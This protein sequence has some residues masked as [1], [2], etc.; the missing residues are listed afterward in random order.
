MGALDVALNSAVTIGSGAATTILLDSL[1]FSADPP[2]PPS[3]CEGTIEE[4]HVHGDVTP[5]RRLH[6]DGVRVNS[7]TIQECSW[8]KSFWFRSGSVADP[9]RT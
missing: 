5:P 8:L 4:M 3:T 9:S 7:N 1:V 2:P 6:D